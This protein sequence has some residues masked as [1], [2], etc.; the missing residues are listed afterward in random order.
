LNLGSLEK[1]PVL[2]TTEPS[3]QLLGLSNIK[4]SQRKT[5]KDQVL[6]ESQTSIIIIPGAY[7][8]PLLATD[9]HDFPGVPLCS[10]PTKLR[11]AHHDG[12]SRIQV[13]EDRDVI[14]PGKR[15]SLDASPLHLA[16]DLGEMHLHVCDLTY[17]LLQLMQSMVSSFHVDFSRS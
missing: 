12:V 1:Q 3:Q 5:K 16:T 15:L 11:L 13:L 4:E 9:Y 17:M 6:K 8:L 14:S 7:L 10:L 2:L